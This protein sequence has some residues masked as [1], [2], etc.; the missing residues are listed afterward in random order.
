MRATL[1]TGKYLWKTSFPQQCRKE[2]SRPLWFRCTL[3]RC[4]AVRAGLEVEEEEEGPSGGVLPLRLRVR[5]GTAA[6]PLRLLRIEDLRVRT[7]VAAGTVVA[8]AGGGRG[9]GAAG[10][11]PGELPRSRVMRRLP[12]LADRYRLLT[13][14][15]R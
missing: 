13:V 11:A 1:K 5:G 10:R 14:A 3:R 6:A 12:C 4:L 2:C 8:I 7:A 15:L 9:Q